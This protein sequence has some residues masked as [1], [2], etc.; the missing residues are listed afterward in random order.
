VM[1]VLPDWAQEGGPDA[2]L[3]RLQDRRCGPG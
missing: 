1:A 3:A 2:I